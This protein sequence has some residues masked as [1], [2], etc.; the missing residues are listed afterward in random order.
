MVAWY[1]ILKL[2]ARFISG[3]YEAA[4]AAARKAEALLWASDA[5]IQLLDYHYYSAL[6]IAAVHETDRPTSAVAR[7]T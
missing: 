3:D 7:A 5:H 4:I 1:W 2:Q 6:I